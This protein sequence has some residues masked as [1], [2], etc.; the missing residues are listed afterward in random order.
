[1]NSEINNIMENRQNR[2]DNMA[3]DNRKY[4][5]YDDG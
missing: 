4:A 1:M 5:T 3:D 2:F